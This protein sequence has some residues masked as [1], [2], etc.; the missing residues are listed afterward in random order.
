MNIETAVNTLS[1]AQKELNKAM[2]AMKKAK[3]ENS[4]KC[5]APKLKRTFTYKKCGVL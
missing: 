1:E 5:D 3:Q 4:V 2:D